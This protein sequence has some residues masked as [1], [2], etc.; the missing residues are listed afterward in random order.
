M[1]ILAEKA[2]LK[3]EK[4]VWGFLE[5]GHHPSALKQI[6]HAELILWEQEMLKLEVQGCSSCN[7]TGSSC[8]WQI[9]QCGRLPGHQAAGG[10][11][12][13][14]EEWGQWGPPHT[15]S[16]GQHL[17]PALSWA[18]APLA[19]Q[20]FLCCFHGGGFPWGIVSGGFSLPPNLLST[21]KSPG[22]IKPACAF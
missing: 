15:L 21:I 17:L 18:P 14:R 2:T 3:S 6:A 19:F 13:G 8:P 9:R 5:T 11:A 12:W 20:S 10:A 16:S 4:A 7:L 22:E 1:K